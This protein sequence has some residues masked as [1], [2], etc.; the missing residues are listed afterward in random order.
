MKAYNEIPE[1]NEINLRKPEFDEEKRDYFDSRVDML[2][3]ENLPRYNTEVLVTD[4]ESIWVDS[5]GYDDDD[6]V[7]L[8]GTG[9]D[10]IGVIAW[11]PLP[12]PYKG[13]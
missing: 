7:Y 5:F 2:I 11:M 13:E 3:A 12:N 6:G 4:G 8:S 9:D 1:W 10:M